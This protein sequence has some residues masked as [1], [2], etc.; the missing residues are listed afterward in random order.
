MKRTVRF[1]MLPIV[2]GL[3]LAG[4]ATPPA[5][6]EYKESMTPKERLDKAF[7]VCEEAPHAYF[8]LCD[9]QG[10]ADK[11]RM[12]ALDEVTSSPIVPDETRAEYLKTVADEDKAF[13]DMKRALDE[14]S[15]AVVRLKA[16]AED[17]QKADKK[18]NSGV[19]TAM[20]AVESQEN[21]YRK[22]VAKYE[23]GFQV[24]EKQRSLK[25]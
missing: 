6:T 23:Q 12:A 3:L 17:Y 1:V 19:V 13:A 5:V 7:K 9:A 25:P 24:W 11:A 15:A 8:A 4:C 2:A 22:N 18:V 10:A 20:R 21:E 14:W 16:A